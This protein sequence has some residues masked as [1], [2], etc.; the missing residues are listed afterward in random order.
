M[1]A[2]VTGATGFIGSHLVGAL[3]REGFDVACLVRST[4]KLNYIE[5]LHVTLVKGDCTEKESLPE[6]VKGVDY[7]FHLAGLTKA[8]SE[9]DYFKTNVKG[10]ENIVNAVLEF[11]PG[12]KRFVCLSSLAAAG[13][14]F[15][16]SPLKEDCKTMPV[17]V[18]GR[19]KL[20]GEKIAY[21]CRGK[22]PVT[23]IRPPVVYGPRDRDLLV[24]F[25]MVK[26]GIIP[27]WGKCWYSFLYVED[28]IN[29]IILSALSKDAEGEIF[30]MSDGN[31]YSSDEIIDAISDAVQ[32]RPLKLRVP[33]FIMPVLAVISEKAKG[34]NIINRDK[35]RE[36][37]Y[38]QW[39]CDTSK[40]ISMLK[41]EP[42][43]K[44]KEG[45]KWTADWYR[46]HQ[47]L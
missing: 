28:L 39:T 40:A 9:D 32:R 1:K 8:C 30:F 4:S 21:G 14:C 33:G 20:E 24:F 7:V 26:S 11:N 36:M 10:T 37:K 19:T 27:Y 15:D 17:S 46:I 31:I 5:D 13:P 23:I 45:A 47:W 12:I 42:R 6:A 18:Y 3:V 22:L 44:I 16:G 2:L 29:G 38:S 34:V 41:F 43:V 25:K 35:I